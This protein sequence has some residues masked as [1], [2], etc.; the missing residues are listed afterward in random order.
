MGNI[1]L[2]GLI[3]CCSCSSQF[4]S[5]DPLDRPLSLLLFLHFT[6]PTTTTN[7]RLPHHLDIPHLGRSSSRSRPR[8]TKRREPSVSARSHHPVLE[9][10]VLTPRRVYSLIRTCVILTISCCWLMYVPAPP[11]SSVLKETR[12]AD[13]PPR[14]S[15]P[16]IVPLFTRW[17]ITYLAQLHPLISAYSLPLTRLDS[18]SSKLER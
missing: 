11:S 9:A 6:T 5:F 12:P 13:D 15:V 18:S 4:A 10:R 1:F 3:A 14:G 16:L 8:R 2:S 17:A 7:E